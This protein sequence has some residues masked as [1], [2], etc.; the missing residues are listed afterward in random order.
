MDFDLSFAKYLFDNHK[1][2]NIIG[3]S[4]PVFE[5]FSQKMMS[6]SDTYLPNTNRVL[7]ISYTYEN[8]DKDLENLKNLINENKNIINSNAYIIFSDG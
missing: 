5:M 1:N 3:I 2:S 7:Q 4:P 6:Y 8:L